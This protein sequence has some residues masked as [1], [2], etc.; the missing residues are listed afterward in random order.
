MFVGVGAPTCHGEENE[1]SRTFAV[2]SLS[3][4]VVPSIGCAKNKYKGVFSFMFFQA[5]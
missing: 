4:S 1:S 2:S 3:P 5:F